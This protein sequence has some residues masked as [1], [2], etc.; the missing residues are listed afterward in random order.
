MQKITPFLWFNDKAE[1]AMNYYISTFKDAKIL[2]M[3]RL[4]DGKIMTGSFSIAD[5]EFNVINGGP[6]YSF[7]PAVSFMIHCEDQ[8]EVNDLWKKLADG[9]QEMNCGWITDKYGVTWQV[10]PEGMGEMLSDKDH[11][12]SNRAMQAMMQMKKID[13]GMMRKAFDGE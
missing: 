12:K 13:L 3:H 2:E 8:E 11:E 6:M 7:T 1:E 9:G 10:I 4:D 5:Q